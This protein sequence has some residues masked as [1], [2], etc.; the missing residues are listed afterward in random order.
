[1]IAF[2]EHHFEAVINQVKLIPKVGDFIHQLLKEFLSAEKKK[3]H[4]NPNDPIP[5]QVSLEKN[6][7][8]SSMNFFQAQST[9]QMAMNGF[10]MLMVVVFL[11]S[12]VNSLAQKYH[13]RR[14]TALKQQKVD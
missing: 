12:L 13:K 11:G 14:C 4:R 5:E 6:R 3:I 2:S 7:V 8:F 9:I 1:M 10:I